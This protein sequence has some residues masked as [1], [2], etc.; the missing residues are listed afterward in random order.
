MVGGSNI[1]ARYGPLKRKL[2]RKSEYAVQKPSTVAIIAVEIETIKLFNAAFQMSG[3]L[4][5]FTYH[6]VEKLPRGIVGKRCELK[7]NTTLNKIG[8]KTK[9]KIA[10][11]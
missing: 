8:A 2:Y 6:S 4:K 11:T 7:E 10:T 9:M 5:I 3:S 1:S